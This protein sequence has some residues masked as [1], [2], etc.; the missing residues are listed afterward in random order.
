MVRGG[1]AAAVGFYEALGLERQDV[2]V[3]GRFLGTTEA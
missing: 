3:F 1:N 2:V